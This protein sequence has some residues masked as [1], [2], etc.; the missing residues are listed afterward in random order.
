MFESLHEAEPATGLYEQLIT[1]KLQQRIEELTQEGWDVT[2]APVPAAS[3]SQALARHVSQAMRQQLDGMTTY[4]QVIAANLT[5]DSL[6]AV[7]G[8]NGV[9]ELVAEEP[10]HVVRLAKLGDHTCP[11]SRPT[12]PLSETT[13]LTN[14]S[15]D[16]RLGPELR[17]ELA[18]AD[19]VDLLCSFVKWSGLRLLD[20][21]LT[22]AKAR[23]I[24]IR[25]VTTT[26]MGATEKK[27]LDHL[28]REHGAE[29]RIA[30]EEHGTRLHAKAWHFHRDTGYDTAYVSS[31]NLSDPALLEGLEWNIRLSTLAAPEAMKKFEDTFEGYWGSPQFEPYDP[32][33][34]SERLSAALKRA[35]WTPP[36]KGK[37]A[38]EEGN[39]ESGVLPHK[40]WIPLP[41]QRDM[42][43]RLAVERQ[44]NSRNKNLLVA[45][46]GTGKTVMAAF[47]YL[48]LCGKETS[49]RPRLLFIAHRKEILKQALD[50]YRSVLK[51]E[52]FGELHVG[53]HRASTWNHVFASIQ[54]FTSKEF[55]SSFPPD[56][57]D[58]VVID[59]FHHAAADTYV[60]LTGHFTPAQLL[61]LTATPERRDGQHVHWQYFE[62][63]IAAE[64]RLWEALDNNLLSPF[65]YFGIADESADFRKLEWRGNSYVKSQLSEV[66]AGN[67]QHAKVVVSAVREKV[68]NLE[69][70]R[71]LG[72]C[73]SIAHAKFMA[74]WFREQGFAAE[75]LD[76][77]TPDHQREEALNALKDGSLQALFSVDLFNEGLDIPDVDTLLFLR[78]TESVTVYLQQFGRGLRRSRSKEVLTVLD[79]VGLHKSE[80]NYEA[81][82]RALTN[83]GNRRLIKSIEA[84]FPQLPPGCE[85]LLDR[86][87]KKLIIDNIKSRLD[88][89]VV[90]LAKEVRDLGKVSL[91]QYLA[92]SGRQ[93][94]EIY[95]NNH[96][97]TELLRRAKLLQTPVPA[98]EGKLLNR[99]TVFL[100]TDDPD[101]VAAYKELLTENSPRYE[102]LPPRKQLYARMLFFILWPD[103]DTFTTYEE[104]LT[105]LRTQHAFL[106][107]AEQVLD[108]T[109]AQ[110]DHLP[111]ELPEPHSDIPLRVHASYSKEE[112]LTAFSETALDG[113]RPRSFREGVRW[114]QNVDV[115]ALLITL[116]KSEKDF[117]PGTRYD[118]YAISPTRFHSQSQS[119]TSE[120]TGA[121]LRYQN[122]QAKGSHI[123]L[124]VRLYK[125]T[126]IGSPHPWVFL[127]TGDYVSHKGSKPM[128]ITWDLHYELPGDILSYSMNKKD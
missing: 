88:L 23:G 3:T 126:E 13:L 50:T 66:L 120:A 45:A 22:T 6:R 91:A 117:T 40:E 80:Y 16:A 99:M 20:A 2:E 65:H 122:H 47:D 109:L 127:G 124:F 55:L 35:G 86:K 18:S 21:E 111:I 76:A 54:S 71:A 60:R 128:S 69:D 14:T 77:S 64:M 24:P 97:W 84:D 59:E 105:F 73:V 116:D 48:D 26:Y 94:H 63:R 56:Y 123:F 67:E 46:T 108:Y 5:L 41:H 121:G 33:E 43:E 125:Y 79:F 70:M 106:A 57:F 81:R 34:D 102:D 28:V 11:T 44:L 82:L 100:H 32:D 30:Y 7:Q 53:G 115:D 112:I 4:E 12:S 96:S 78:P 85:I 31:S 61:G 101:R 95:R 38:A 51:D 19:G 104:G 62:G 52:D 9:I 8:A 98:G 37:H 93:I 17:A 103:G 10:R 110:A 119:T 83:L 72:F 89:K 36:K 107:E 68:A 1:E 27:A 29:V 25:V 113:F 90:D 92:E 58:I 39:G 118:D 42:L 15:G 75:A 74:Q 87:S 114:C 49:D